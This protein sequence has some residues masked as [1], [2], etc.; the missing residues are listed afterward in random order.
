MGAGS[1]SDRY[2]AG[3]GPPLVLLHGLGATWRAWRPVLP[4]LTPHHDVLAITL[5]GHLGGPPLPDAM[6]AAAFVDRVGTELD[7]EGIGVAHLAGSS[8]G[9]WL[10][11]EL[12][13]R[14][15]ALSVVAFAPAGLLE[16]DEV[17]RLIRKL[18]IQHAA[19]SRLGP[20]ARMLAGSGL[21][22][23]LLFGD[24][25][26]RPE[27]LAG[28]E[29]REWVAAFVGCSAFGSILGV[30]ASHPLAAPPG[31]PGC[32]ICIAW[33]AEDRL[34]P[35]HPFAKR[36]ADALPE[37]THLRLPS[38]GHFPMPDAPGQV[39][40]TILGHARGSPLPARQQC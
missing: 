13:R 2:R 38:T 12:A 5:P 1:R 25:L 27:Q 24:V 21:G 23:R 39:A 32:R 26:H 8:L 17:G 10:A 15:R 34:T 11:L 22:R 29:A 31:R 20:V 36:F 4:A 9:G 35:Y 19:A 28:G 7:R 16:P 37:A 3:S 6:T 33:P 40:E 14:G 30:L 18:R